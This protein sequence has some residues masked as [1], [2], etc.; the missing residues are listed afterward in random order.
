MN[1]K[2][3]L[4][5][6]RWV[7]LVVAVSAFAVYL[8]TLA[9]SVTFI[10]SGELATVACTLGIAHP[11]GYPLFTLFG[12]VF[13][14]L[15]IAGEQILRL[16]IMAAVFCAAGVFVFF[17]LTHLLLTTAT[18]AKEMSA[19]IASVGASLLLGFSETY[20]SQATSVEVYSLH[21]LFLSL[22][23]YCFMRATLYDEGRRGKQAESSA[24]SETKW[25]MLFAFM[26]GLSFTNHM[27]T[28]LLAPGLLY[29]YFVSRGSGSDSWQRILR[30]VMPFVIGFS[31]YL[32][33]PVRA[34]SGV[35]L[36]WGNPVTL[37]RFLWHLSG[38]QFRVWIFSSTEAAGRQLRYFANSLPHEFAYVGLF[39]AI[40]GAF[41]LFRSNR[42]L[43]IA[44][45]L[46]FISCV[47][48]SINYDIH[49]IDSY[50]L[51]AYFC[52]ALWSAFALF[53]LYEWMQNVA[54]LQSRV[55]AVLII[56]ASLAPVGVHYRMNDESSN[57]LVEDYTKNMFASVKPN[58]LV[59]SYQWDYWVSAA[60][61][62]QIVKK[63]RDDVAVVDKELLRRSWYLLQL[64]RRYPWL[65]QRSKPEVEAFTNELYK[66]EH[67]LPYN[68]SVIQSRYVEMISSFI[69]R[70]IASR[71]V[72]VTS[73]I[74]TEFTGRFQRVPDGLALRLE[75]D[76]VFHGTDV[77]KYEIRP[78]ERKGRLEDMVKNLYLSS[79]KARAVYYYQHG[80]PDEPR[81]I[82]N[83]A[84]EITTK[85]GST[86]PVQN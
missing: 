50:F 29:L 58:A 32:Y 61:Y 60:Y 15:P 66:F 55:G 39:L 81:R 26:L 83:L 59:I 63:Y 34:A 74:E 42:K 85:L 78:F 82:S 16:N 86:S 76:S 14:N 44:V 28:I 68:P 75:A 71:P 37:E 65:I 9:P 54:A 51:L 7:G 1:L 3:V 27:T 46:L 70:N 41:I 19:L 31:V 10:D 13:S 38:K 33:L 18:K 17:Q 73:E 23:L 4:H 43:A 11:T 2:A 79:L 22:V 45:L 72:Y 64:Q 35:L 25:W 5:S 21:V 62:F 20:W 30:M 49:D 24:L 57:N 48:Y 12:W 77:P 53:R 40:I 80:F 52:I 36:N 84:S 69:S 67:D 47:L 8:K 56:A 6:P